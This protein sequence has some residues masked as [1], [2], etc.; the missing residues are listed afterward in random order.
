MRNENIPY[1]APLSLKRTERT[2]AVFLDAESNRFEIAGKSMPENAHEFYQKLNRWLDDYLCNP[3]QKTEFHIHLDSFN[4][5]T[6]K[7]LL[8]IFYKLNAVDALESEIT[9]N[10]YY[11]TEDEEML[12]AGEDYE[13]MVQLPFEFI[14]VDQ[15]EMLMA[16]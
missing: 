14:A 4:T 3:N 5:P 1:V 10:W 8:Q 9:I 2:P 16:S 13:F 15:N 7:S 6:S 11:Y 12:E